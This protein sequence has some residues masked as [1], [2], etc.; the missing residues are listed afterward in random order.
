MQPIRQPVR[1]WFGG[2]GQ[3]RYGKGWGVRNRS[4]AYFSFVAVY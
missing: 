2:V 1:C 4:L 3:I